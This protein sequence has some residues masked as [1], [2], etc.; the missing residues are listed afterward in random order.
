MQQPMSRKKAALLIGGVLVLVMAVVSLIFFLMQSDENQFGKFI[1]IQNYGQKVKNLPSD[2]RDSMESYL[3]NVV[4]MNVDDSVN[5]SKIKDA[6]IRDKSNTQELN[7]QTSVYDGKFIVDIESI[8]QSYLVQYSYSERN[9]IDVGG[10]PVVVSCLPEDQLIYGP[11][12]CTDLVSSQTTEND[13]LLQ[14]LPYENFSFKILPDATQGEDLVLVVTLDIS[15]ADL[16]GNAQ[17][18]A[19]T[20]A[21]YK[22]QVTDWIKSK[23]ADPSKYTFQYNYDDA[24]N[25]IRQVDHAHGD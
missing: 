11:F 8:K 7:R 13:V 16:K 2:M 10:N 22:K 20:V 24:G 5:A 12:E 18:K 14:Y 6:Y 1:R 9:T 15:Q 4:T 19:Q 23:G 17:S 25:I 3:Y 21:M